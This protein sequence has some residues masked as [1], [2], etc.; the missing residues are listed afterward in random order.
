MVE[1]DELL[2]ISSIV[3]EAVVTC[4]NSDSD[5]VKDFI[6]WPAVRRDSEPE[7]GSEAATEVSLDGSVVA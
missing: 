6:S 3:L 4:V 5:S 2:E 1:F 7:V